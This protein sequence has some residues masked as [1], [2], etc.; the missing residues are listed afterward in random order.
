MTLRSMTAVGLA[1]IS[2]LFAVTYANANWDHFKPP[3]AE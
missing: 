3:R 1:G 2:M